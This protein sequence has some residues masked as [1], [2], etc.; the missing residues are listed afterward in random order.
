M[1]FVTHDIST[2]MKLCERITVIK[3][4]RV[5][6]SGD[7]GSVTSRPKSEYTRA[8]IAANFANREFRR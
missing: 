1:L 4:G 2:A 6:E 8:L 3:D 5:V 7:M